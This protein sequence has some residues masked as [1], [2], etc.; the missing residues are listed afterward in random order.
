MSFTSYG[1]LGNL[2]WGIGCIEAL[3]IQARDINSKYTHVQSALNNNNTSST[4]QDLHPAALHTEE[5]KKL[6]VFNNGVRGF[7]MTSSTGTGTSTYRSVP[8]PPLGFELKDQTSRVI[9]LSPSHDGMVF[10]AAVLTDNEFENWSR[11]DRE[12]LALRKRAFTDQPPD[13]IRHTQEFRANALASLKRRHEQIDGLPS[14]QRAVLHSV[15]GW[16]SALV[17]NIRLREILIYPL[18]RDHLQGGEQ[19]YV[20][21]LNRNEALRAEVRA[22]RR[23]IYQNASSTH[24]YQNI[25]SIHETW[26]NIWIE[27]KSAYEVPL[28]NYLKTTQVSTLRDICATHDSPALP[29][30]SPPTSHDLNYGQQLVMSCCLIPVTLTP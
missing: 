12:A 16:I 6:D 26:S 27:E 13:V 30:P 3:T 8:F 28:T 23:A 4:S 19:Y 24:W 18:I 10:P 25:A 22:V 20:D 2:G 14:E 11:K 17:V 7:G 21:V 15:A 1:I 5:T 29:E 9:R